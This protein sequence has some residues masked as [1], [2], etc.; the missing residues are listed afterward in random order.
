MAVHLRIAKLD[1]M[2]L[3]GALSA[4]NLKTRVMIYT[5]SQNATLL[6]T[7]QSTSPAALFH[8]EDSLEDFRTAIRAAAAGGSF[9]SPTAASVLR[10]PQGKD[11]PLSSQ[12]LI[13][14]KMLMDGMLNKQICSVLKIA[15]KTVR[16]HR[17]HIYRK[18]KVRDVPGLIHW[19]SRANLEN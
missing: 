10:S 19:M 9:V 16:C 12:E 15:E 3:M 1:G 5:A 13:V 17:E 8:K 7:V 2:L 18:L 6:R 14:A 11:I 4:R